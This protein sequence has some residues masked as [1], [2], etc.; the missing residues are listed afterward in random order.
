MGSVMAAMSQNSL[1]SVDWVEEPC[2]EAL[3]AIASMESRPRCRAATMASGSIKEV[4]EPAGMGANT[5]PTVMR[6]MGAEGMSWWLVGV[7]VVGEAVAVGGGGGE[8]VED[9]SI[10]RPGAMCKCRAH[11]GR[12]S[13][14]MVGKFE[15]SELRSDYDRMQFS[16]WGCM[17]VAVCGYVY[18]EVCIAL[19]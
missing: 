4:L 17:S 19:Q 14:S 16:L 6:G 13:N 12:Y 3:K 7:A 10:M 11:A 1:G 9:D 18:N 5:L 2:A 8:E 15:R